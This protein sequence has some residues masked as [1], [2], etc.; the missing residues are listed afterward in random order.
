M[1]P[2]D[3]SIYRSFNEFAP[4]R[5]QVCSGEG[6]E[7]E[8]HL[9]PYV[10]DGSMCAAAFWDAELKK[11]QVFRSTLFFWILKVFA[12]FYVFLCVGSSKYPSERLSKRSHLW[13][14]RR[15]AG[16]GS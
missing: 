5:G 11:S 16:P 8:C 14:V 10:D 1:T 4:V 7:W 3:H 9:A 13:Q 6:M 15:R 2:K 12:K